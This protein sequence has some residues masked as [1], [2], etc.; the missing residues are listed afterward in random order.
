MLHWWLQGMYSW[1]SVRN[2]ILLFLPIMRAISARAYSYLLDQ[3]SVYE[4]SLADQTSLG[5]A[6][7]T[8]VVMVVTYT[9]VFGGAVICTMLKHRYK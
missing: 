3:V 5:A 4:A 6:E 1:N 8:S 9:T 7:I 2:L